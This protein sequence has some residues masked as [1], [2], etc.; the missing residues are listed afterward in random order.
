MS[1]KLVVPT[2]FLKDFPA[3]FFLK[4]AFKS[5]FCQE[6]KL[7]DME[8]DIFVSTFD[9]ESVAILDRRR[10]D[11]IVENVSFYFVI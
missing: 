2:S 1:E 11:T 8:E 5:V 3:F 10:D 6:G 7:L 9:G 4:I